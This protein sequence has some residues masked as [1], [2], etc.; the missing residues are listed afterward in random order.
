ME[1]GDRVIVDGIPEYFF[2]TEVHKF[3][4]TVSDTNG[5]TVGTFGV[6]IVRKA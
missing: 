1:R 6:D 2:V 4:V 3:S 5:K